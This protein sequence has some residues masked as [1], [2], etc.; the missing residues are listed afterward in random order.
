LIQYLTNTAELRPDQLRGFF[1]GWP[2]QPSPETHLRILQASTVVALALDTSSERV[3]GFG[4]ALSDGVLSAYIPLLE[5]LAEHRAQGIGSA[6][7]RS[8]LD[9]LGELYMVDLTCDREAQAFYARLGFTPSV[10]M[11]LRRYDRQSG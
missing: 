2:R 11:I 10:G 3:V 7:V 9:Q 6:L 4:T 1:A 5:V 8:L